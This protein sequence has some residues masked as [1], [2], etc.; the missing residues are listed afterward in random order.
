[1][2]IDWSHLDPQETQILLRI[3]EKAKAMQD[4]AYFLTEL[5]EKRKQDVNELLNICKKCRDETCQQN[6]RCEVKR[7]YAL[8]YMKQEKTFL[9]NIEQKT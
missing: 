5:Q 1:M 8:L 3:I 7:A 4:E 6:N 9:E 2:S